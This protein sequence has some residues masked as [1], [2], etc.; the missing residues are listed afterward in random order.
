IIDSGSAGGWGRL[1][2]TI[3]CVQIYVMSKRRGFKSI[4]A[5]DTLRIHYQIRLWQSTFNKHFSKN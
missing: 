4:A 2:S 5:G 1:Y 3:G